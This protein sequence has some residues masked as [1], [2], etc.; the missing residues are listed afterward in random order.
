MM[1]MTMTMTMIA[2]P[3]RS[4]PRNPAPRS[5]PRQ[6]A[7]KRKPAMTMTMTTTTMIVPPRKSLR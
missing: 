3:R 6:L 2:L 7:R 1:K 5:L 4:L